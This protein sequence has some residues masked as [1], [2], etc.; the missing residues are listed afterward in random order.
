M[1]TGSSSIF[2]FMWKG[3][4]ANQGGKKIVN[5]SSVLSVYGIIVD[6]DKMEL[7]LPYD[8]IEKNR[9]AL[10]SHHKRKKI[11]LR[12]LQSLIGQLS[13]VCIVVCPGRAS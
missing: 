6:S 7:R 12:E 5:P 2:V 13:H 11:Q 9:A 10:A 1:L 3:W 8:K 4:N